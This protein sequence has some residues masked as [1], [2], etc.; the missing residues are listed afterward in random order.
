[1]CGS[2][3]LKSSLIS[4]YMLFCMYTMGILNGVR[5]LV[6][7][8]ASVLLGLM[9]NPP[10][11]RCF[12]IILVQIC[13]LCVKIWFGYELVWQYGLGIVMIPVVFWCCMG[14]RAVKVKVQ[15]RRYGLR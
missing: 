7:R 15:V 2:C 12:V 8:I 10:Q 5:C 6:K 11:C 4:R 14:P 3:N 9:C 13:R 1:M